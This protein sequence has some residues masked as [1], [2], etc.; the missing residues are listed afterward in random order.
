MSII[1]STLSSILKITI[2]EKEDWTAYVK[3]AIH[4]DFY[5]TWHYHSLAQNG[6]PILC[7]YVEDNNFIA[8]PLLQRE[9]EGTNY[10]DFHSV[11]GYS[12]P[13]S[14]LSFDEVP[15]AMLKSF[16]TSLLDFIKQENG[17]S[18]FSKLHPF[19]KQDVL[20]RNFDGLFDNGKTV[21]IDLRVPVEIQRKGYRQTTLDAI[22]KCRRLGYNMV[23]A[24]TQD[25]IAEFTQLYQK[26]MNRIHAA[27][28]YLFDEAY[29]TKLINTDEY[30]CKLVLIKN[31]GELVCGSIIML[32]HGI[33]QGHLIATNEKYLRHSPAKLLVD[34]VSILGRALGMQFYHLG[35]GLGF[36]EN[37]LFEWKLGFSQLTLPYKSWRLVANKDVYITLVKDNGQDPQND[38]DFFPLYRLTQS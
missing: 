5:H 28:F 32:N 3:K 10:N 4:S 27:D 13:I 11:Y 26:N 8:I 16:K 31:D 29:F 15:A 30:L 24:A 38:V 34:E 12:G 6:R 25:D 7:V 22:K 19:F 2:A 23:E 20:I 14:N 36:K 37:S 9:I 18:V 35:G 21:A 33:I 17:V 1:N